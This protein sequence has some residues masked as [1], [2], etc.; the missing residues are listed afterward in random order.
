MRG[1][2]EKFSGQTPFLRVRISLALV[3]LLFSI[4]GC[5]LFS[6]PGNGPRVSARSPFVDQILNPEGGP[7]SRS[8]TSSSC[9]ELLSIGRRTAYENSVFPVVRNRCSTCHGST[10]SPLFAVSDLAQSFQAAESRIDEQQPDQSRLVIKSANG[11]CGANCQGTGEEMLTA[12]NQ[13]ISLASQFQ[14]SAMVACGGDGPPEIE[15]P[16]DA[17]P[18][19]DLSDLGPSTRAQVP[20]GDRQYVTNVLL[21]V[22]GPAAKSVVHGSILSK[23]GV[24]GGPCDLYENAMIEKTRGWI[25]ASQENRCFDNF[26][27]PVTVDQ[28]EDNYANTQVPTSKQSNTIRAGWKIAACEKIVEI[29]DARNFAIEKLFRQIGVNVSGS[30]PPGPASDSITSAFHLFYPEQPLSGAALSSLQAVSSGIGD[31]NNIKW[32]WILLPLCISAGWEVP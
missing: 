21:D 18:A 25:W 1:S 28:A 2:L 10:Q 26:Y 4:S 8:P 7:G 12:V 5:N 30:T 20:M 13:F 9:S 23:P 17:G 24:F 11:H 31:S 22:F 14:E 27:S 16:G 29:A 19:V 3:T 6:R 15:P 32:K